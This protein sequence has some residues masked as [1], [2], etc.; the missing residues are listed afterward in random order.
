MPTISG[1]PPTHSVSASDELPVSQGGAVRSTSIGT[2]LASA[3]P[4]IVIT[5][6]AL[7]G[8]TSLGTGSPEQIAV[9]E[10]VSL[11]NG[12]LVANGYDHAA[13]PA[14]D[15]LPIS[16]Q[17]VI[18][19]GGSPRLMPTSLI[20][21]LF[22]PGANINIDANG[23]ISSAGV[24]QSS[25]ATSFISQLQVVNALAGQDLVAV[26]QAGSAA[27]ISYSNFLNGITI[28]QAQAAGPANDIDSLWVAQGSNVMMSQTFSAIWVWIS[29]KIASY[30]A[31]VVEVTNDI[32]LDATIHN[33]RLLVCSQSVTLTP[34]VSNMG[35]GFQCTVINISPG[36]VLLGSGFL[37]STGS[38]TL[39]PQQS[40]TLSCFGYS[41]GLVAYAQMPSVPGSAGAVL[42]SQVGALSS[43]GVTTSTITV[44]WQPPATGG[45]VSAYSVQFRATGATAW[46]SAL[47]SS[48]TQLISGLQAATSYD[49]CVV[50]QNVAGSS[51][52]SA[53]LTVMTSA[54][55]RNVP[56]QPTN[57]TAASMTSSSVRLSW[58]GA[59]DLNPATNY[60]VE[61]RRAGTSSWT[62]VTG[63]TGTVDTITGLQAS[64][65]YEFRVTGINSAGPGLASAIVSATTT[66]IGSSV[67]G[68][69]WNL[70]P[71]G[72][73]ARG[74]GAIGVN[75]HVSPATSPVRFGFSATASTAPDTW[76][77]A[78]LVNTD[79][80]GAYVPTPVTA[81][82]WYA[83]V[84]GLDGSGT[85]ISAVPFT[86]Q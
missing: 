84:E 81:G 48:T 41:G 2:L 57:V 8:R 79:L 86:V 15:R 38:P 11:S 17:V 31:P 9:G 76:T 1:L 44:S 53:I 61:Y 60:T 74:N 34:L 69:T 62:S 39:L 18:D 40:A 37:S 56:S 22:S 58:S 75:A 71:V 26:S 20:R 43:A 68:I 77:A 65:G 16:S 6:P 42:P 59:A 4:T 3:Q 83:W 67:S 23:V 70:A 5:P 12:T 50:A 52:P 51:L 54:S 10:G 27:A 73:Y 29:Q 28:D 47:A 80:W 36:N 25:P 46:S 35:S 64:T 55:M 33:G 7:L 66:A 82:T 24:N 14:V 85:S 63:I 32:N 21:G 30:K 19:D 45:P 49:I 72:P 13:F 78:V